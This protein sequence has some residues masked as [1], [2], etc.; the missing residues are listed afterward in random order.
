MQLGSIQLLIISVIL[1][2]F[3]CFHIGVSF[4]RGHSLFER[5]FSLNMKRKDCIIVGA[6]LSGLTAS[7]YLHQKGVDCVLVEDS[8]RVGGNLVSKEGITV[9]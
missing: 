8:N 2:Q 4:S 6:G 3:Q 9:S 7:Y 5:I 1:D